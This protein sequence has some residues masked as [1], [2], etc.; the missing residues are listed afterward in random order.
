MSKFPLLQPDGT[1]L[2]GDGLV[3]VSRESL[4]RLKR[5]GGSLPLR[6]IRVR[7]RTTGA[8]LSRLRGRG[9]EF[10]EARPYQAGDEIRHIDW[11]ITART[12]Q[13]YSKLFR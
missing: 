5:Q 10:D 4:I 9:M 13:P 12:G 1:P 3:R 11:R 6:A 8:Y 2:P 7:S